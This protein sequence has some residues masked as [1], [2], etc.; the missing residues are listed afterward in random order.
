MKPHRPASKSQPRL[1]SL[2]QRIRALSTN[3]LLTAESHPLRSKPPNPLTLDPVPTVFRKR[4]SSKGTLRRELGLRLQP[5]RQNVFNSARPAWHHVAVPSA[6]AL[7]L[8]RLFNPIIKP[9]IA[10]DDLRP[11][12][13]VAVARTARKSM[14]YIRRRYADRGSNVGNSVSQ[15]NVLRLLAGVTI[16]P[17]KSVSHAETTM[18]QVEKKLE[19]A[20]MGQR[21]KARPKT[22]RL[23]MAHGRSVIN[24]ENMMTR[25]KSYLPVPIAAAE[26]GNVT[27][28][29]SPPK[30]KVSFQDSVER[31]KK[32][33]EGESILNVSDILAVEEKGSGE[34]DESVEMHREIV[35]LFHCSQRGKQPGVAKVLLGAGGFKK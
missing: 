25:L 27:R 15:D 28:H 9:L 31:P 21:E 30:K 22:G 10:S 17:K 4:M 34:D 24:A 11:S 8:R 13:T 32:E 12:R 7:Q 5:S 2:S 1:G 16:A 20:G 19:T 6:T 14:V 35:E 23:G 3:P 33:S 26:I 29:E 18:I